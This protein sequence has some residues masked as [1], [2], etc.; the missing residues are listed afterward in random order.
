MPNPSL[1]RSSNGLNREALS[2]IMR[3]ADQAVSGRITQT[4]FNVPELC[5][6]A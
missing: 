3:F 1:E 6:T 2:F 4:L 5:T